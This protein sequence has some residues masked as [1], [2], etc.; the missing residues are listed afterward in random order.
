MTRGGSGKDSRRHRR[1][2]P[3][4]TWMLGALVAGFVIVGLV[5]LARPQT[6]EAPSAGASG[7]PAGLRVAQLTTA[8]D[9]VSSDKQTI[10]VLL[11][12]AMPHGTV[13]ATVTTDENCAADAQGYSHCRND[14]RLAD[15]SVLHLRHNHRMDM[16]S[17]LAP[18]EKVMVKRA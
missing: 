12:G 8:S 14:L 18:G 2:R 17:C 9:A 7:A 15:G 16:V 5:L 10:A 11:S 13:Q 6:H 1:G 4:L 3:A